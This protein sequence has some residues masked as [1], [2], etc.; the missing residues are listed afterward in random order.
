MQNS[1]FQ[2]SCTA[3]RIDKDGYFMGNT[4][5]QEDPENK[6]KFLLPPDTV[7]VEPPMPYDPNMRYKLIKK[8]RRTT[9]AAEPKPKPVQKSPEY[10]V[11]PEDM[12]KIGVEF[13]GFR[14]DASYE[15][16]LV[17]REIVRIYGSKNDKTFSVLDTDGIGRDFT[18]IEAFEL[19]DLLQAELFEKDGKI[20]C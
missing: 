9:W 6:G 1:A 16:W 18:A 14:F 13:K 17:L 19:T 20:V 10:E 7:L 15:R 11:M 4:L 3:S 12:P 2:N 5:I 8:G